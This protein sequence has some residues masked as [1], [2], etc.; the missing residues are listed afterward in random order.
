M[1]W[2][3]LAEQVV[4][5]LIP[6]GLLAMVPAPDELTVSENDGGGGVDFEVLPQPV[7]KPPATTQIRNL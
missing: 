4:G 6:A 1:F 7:R 2:L 3:K 5:Q